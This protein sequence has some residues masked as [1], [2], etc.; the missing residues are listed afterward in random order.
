ML[1][2]C[3]E[4][5]PEAKAE[6]HKALERDPLSLPINADVA[7]IYYYARDYAKARDYIQ[8]AL[9]LS[10]EFNQANSLRE[11][12]SAPLGVFRSE[13]KASLIASCAEI[14]PIAPRGIRDAYVAA[15]CSQILSEQAMTLQKGDINRSAFGQ[16]QVF[17]SSG[18]QEQAL[19]WLE[20]SYQIHSFFMPFV[21]VTPS[22]DALR[23]DARYRDIV[24][25]MKFPAN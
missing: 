5:F 4:R 17:A 23:D 20:K 16:A 7:E 13:D 10:N 3:E 11:R 24:R 14:S 8:A 15:G 25:R 18:D 12:I 21:K 1:F 22:F 6:I 2:E 19:A 9:E